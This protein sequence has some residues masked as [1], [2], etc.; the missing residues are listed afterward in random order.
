MSAQR[1]RP[2]GLETRLSTPA[3][4]AEH[5][6]T[7]SKEWGGSGPTRTALVSRATLIHQPPIPAGQKLNLPSRE[8]ANGEPFQFQS[9]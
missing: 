8:T 2:G 7:P 6:R 1:Q 9:F 3:F 4:S 5:R